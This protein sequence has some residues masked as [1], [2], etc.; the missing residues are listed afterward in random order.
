MNIL[1]T[2]PSL[3][4][5]YNVSGISSVVNN[6]LTETDQNYI[7]FL[8]GKK[9][10][11]KRN[12]MWF[13]DQFILPFKFMYSLSKNKIDIFHLNAPLNTLAIMRDFIFLNIA[14]LMGI[15]VLL[16][17]HGGT[18]L[19][20]TPKNKW[21]YKYLEH[22]FN[23]ADHIVVLS[24]LEKDLLLQKYKLKE[25]DITPIENCVTVPD[26]KYK[27]S[28]ET[29]RII[30]LGR[31]VESKGV[32][33]I[34]EA[35]SQLSVRR[36]DFEFNLY[37]TG[38]DQDDVIKQLTATIGENFQYKGIVAG[39]SKFGAYLEADIFLLPSLYGEG[40]PM[41]LLESM[42]YGVIPVVTDD[43]SMATVVE[44]GINGFIVDKNN[45]SQLYNLMDELI[46]KFNNSSIDILQEKARATIKE[47]YNCQYYSI[48]LNKIYEKII[49]EGAD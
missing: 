31:I 18:Y 34:V 11:Q 38:P 13:L 4:T 25:E 29:A 37:G 15:K 49:N 9:D 20:T 2:A 42:S 17:L 39:E 6:I 21:L 32:F 33:N 14:K 1:I 8:V 19:K 48:K 44:N 36:S 40:L 30:F 24:H 43:G 12:M 28:H 7:H 45:S 23:S 35:L 3:D 47:K 5:K 46:E 27:K 10:Q 16:H 26:I 41:A 22:Y